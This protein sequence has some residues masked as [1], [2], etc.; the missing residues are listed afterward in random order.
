M[1]SR[2]HERR[3]HLKLSSS[4]RKLLTS[5]LLSSLS[6]L[7]H[8]AIAASRTTHQ[9]CHQRHAMLGACRVLSKG[10]KLTGPRVC[11]ISAVPH[12][13]LPHTNACVT[14]ESRHHLK[15][16]GGAP[17]PSPQCPFTRLLAFGSSQP[18]PQCPF[19]RLLAF[20]SSLHA[21]HGRTSTSGRPSCSLCT[22]CLSSGGPHSP[23]GLNPQLGP[24]NLAWRL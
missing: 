9:L 19:T 8:Q 12:S 24:Q 5:S 16:N 10:S 3:F 20:G 14:V 11:R 17:Q 21:R 22:A 23:D 13:L 7:L 15:D 4:S 6:L 18:K 2:I 1:C